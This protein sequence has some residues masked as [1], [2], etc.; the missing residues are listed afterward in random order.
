MRMCLFWSLLQPFALSLFP[1]SHLSLSLSC[2]CLQLRLVPGAKE[3]LATLAKKYD[4]VI[5]TSRQHVI[6][7]DT[8][9]WVEEHFPDTFKSILFGNHWGLHGEK[10]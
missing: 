1:L 6:A 2:V 4:L 5:V 3:A 8:H 7:E 9:K 10:K